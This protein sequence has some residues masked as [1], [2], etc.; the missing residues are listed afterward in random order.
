MTKISKESFIGID[1]SKHDLQGYVLPG[2]KERTFPNTPQGI[3]RC[4]TWI[5]THDQIGRLVL[6]PT[7][8]YEKNLLNALW[9]AKMPVSCVNARFVHH[10]GIALK[11]QAKTDLLDS[12]KL[13]LYG[14]T[15]LPKETPPP[16]PLKQDLS[17]LIGRRK[18]L[19]ESLRAEQNRYE[20][21]PSLIILESLERSMTWLRKEIQHLNQKLE[22][23]LKEPEIKPLFDMLNKVKG[24]G[25]VT[26]ANLVADLPELGT[27]SSK[28]IAKLVG[29]APLNKDSGKLL[30]KRHIR[31]GRFHVRR[32]LYMA[33]LVAIQHNQ[34][35]KKIYLKLKS[36]GKKP[37]VALVACM[38][39]FLVWINGMTRKHLKGET[40]ITPT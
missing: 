16:D 29:V 35:L 14:Q 19:V 36:E 27:L 1:I 40:V 28:E 20:K 10:F 23:L 6:E 38:R 32:V 37:K 4:L 18:Q 5:A 34:A 26:I 11:D 15:F 25:L 2:K 9:A 12:Q 22:S 7:G 33:T 24:L 3:K 17:A 30:Q 21:S 31:G 39:K 13:A 8:G